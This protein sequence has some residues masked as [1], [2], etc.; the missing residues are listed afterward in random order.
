MKM[1]QKLSDELA[2]R[3]LANQTTYDSPDKLDMQPVTFYLGVDPSAPSMTI[4]N[5]AVVLLVKHFVN[6]G[7][8]AVLLVGGATGMIGDP[9]GKAQERDLL[10]PEQLAE[11]KKAIAGQYEQ[12]LGKDSFTLVDNYDWFKEINYLDFLRDVG[13][14]VPMRQMVNRDFVKQRLSESGAGIS[15]AEFSY[16]LIQAYDFA[17][18]NKEHDV[19]LQICG[20]DQ[21]GNSIAGV[22]LVRRMNGN[23]VHVWSAPLVVN[24]A[25]GKKFGKTED[26]AVW[27]DPEMTSPFQFYQFW[28]NIDD[29]GV[30][31]YLK[32]Y[33]L[34]G[35]DDIR[36]LMEDFTQ[37]PGGRAAQ[38][39]LAY[40][41]TKIVHGSEVADQ[42]VKLTEVLFGQ[43]SFADLSN[44]EKAMLAK[45]FPKVPASEDLYQ[46]LVDTDLAGSKGE[47]RTFHAAGA[48]S[49]NG[50]KVLPN[51]PIDWMSGYNLLKRGKNKFAVVEKA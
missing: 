29:A 10:T 44:D 38:K 13:K 22:D 34:L 31:D 39:V 32:I 30:E 4:G 21:W 24:K 8:K 50:Q 46:M 28:L 36:K 45:E 9:D 42:V 33:T 49:V 40:E 23:E 1:N 51:Q 37:N 18:L 5:L 12:I 7:H 11:N 35:Q 3:G 20:S 6:A 19:N 43:T 48:I 15:Y 26:G 47:A 27:L 2:W 41:V 17:H 25:T 14:H 16:V